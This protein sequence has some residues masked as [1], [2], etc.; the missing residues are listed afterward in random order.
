MRDM[1]RDTKQEQVCFYVNPRDLSKAIGNKRVN[2]KTL[3][4]EKGINIVV[5]SDKNVENGKIIWY[6][7]ANRYEKYL[8][9]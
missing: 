5:K 6:N 3:E 1:L 9:K 2:I 8:K 4:Q 7:K